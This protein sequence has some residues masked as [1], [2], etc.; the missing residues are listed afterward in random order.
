LRRTRCDGPRKWAWPHW[1]DLLPHV[2]KLRANCLECLIFQLLLEIETVDWFCEIIVLILI[3]LAIFGRAG[4]DCSRASTVAFHVGRIIPRY[5]P[6]QLPV[7]GIS[8]SYAKA[9]AN[10]KEQVPTT[11][12]LW[13][14]GAKR[15][16]LKATLFLSLG[17]SCHPEVITEFKAFR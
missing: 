4:L 7:L 11:P 6:I 9:I 15:H 5:P 3:T 2:G 1:D 12:P 10:P 17:L 14:V 13:H 16:H 8:Y